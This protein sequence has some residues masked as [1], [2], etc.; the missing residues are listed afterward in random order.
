[1]L[2]I[3]HF[4]GR[5]SDLAGNLCYGK[6]QFL[7]NVTDIDLSPVFIIEAKSPPLGITNSISFQK[8]E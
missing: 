1:M 4:K 2:L 8:G 6:D 5:Q 7:R 3:R